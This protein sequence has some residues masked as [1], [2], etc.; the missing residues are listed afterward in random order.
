MPI[1]LSVYSATVPN[2]TLIDL[3]GITRVAIDDQPANIE[4]I[5]KEMATFYCKDSK[6]IILCVIP[7]NQ[8]LSTQDSLVLAKKLDPHGHR[9]LGVLTKVD[10]MDEGTDCSN[11]LLNKEIKLKLGYIAVKGRSQ[12]DIKNK[13]SVN[14]ARR[15]ERDFFFNH[16]IYASLPKNFLGT[17]SLIKSLS[18][19][20]FDVVKK[21]LPKIKLEIRDKI[22]RK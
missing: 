14:D 3:P 11:V 13:V 18:D 2:L 21:E 7:A 16:P 1:I 4:E 6:T 15:K 12:L 8:D 19:I 22:R 20:F 17:E 10:I 5:T 9:T